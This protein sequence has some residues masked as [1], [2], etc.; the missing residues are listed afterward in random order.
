MVFRMVPA[1]MTDEVKITTEQKSPEEKLIDLE[2][3][4]I[5]LESA[6]IARDK[7]AHELAVLKLKEKYTVL[8]QKT[9]RLAGVVDPD[10][11]NKARTE[12]YH[13]SAT[14]PGEP[15]LFDINSPGGSFYDG[16]ELY[17]IVR[18]LSN[19]G[20]H[21]TTRISGYACSMGGV[22]AQAGDT[23]QIREGSYLHL[24]EASYGVIG[25][26]HEMREAA[27]QTEKITHDMARLYAKRSA[28]SADEIYENLHRKEWWLN[29]EEAFEIGFVDLIL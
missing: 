23:R 15:L 20:H 7:A 16:M 10:S 19:A 11:V 26:A 29:A 18:E 25:K 1:T 13:L 5:N 22:L 17:G 28:L 14:N 24:H 8:V 21:M 3:S 9:V 27:E 12:L 6:V 2:T 4:R